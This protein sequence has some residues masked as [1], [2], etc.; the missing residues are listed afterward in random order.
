MSRR[1]SNCLLGKQMSSLFTADDDLELKRSD[2]VKLAQELREHEVFV[3]H[4]V[5]ESK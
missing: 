3:K 1:D 5:S 4:L 2:F